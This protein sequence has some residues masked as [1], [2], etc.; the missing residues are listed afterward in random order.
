MGMNNDRYVVKH[1]DGWTVKKPGADRASSI[2]ET[3][4]DAERAA[5]EIVSNRGGGGTPRAGL[6]KEQ[7]YSQTAM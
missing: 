3:Q 6:G 2:H 5:K 1:E 4:R 7:H